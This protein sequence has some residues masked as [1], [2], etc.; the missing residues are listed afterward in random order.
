MCDVNHSSTFAFPFQSCFKVLG[1]QHHSAKWANF[2]G[3]DR[4]APV[5][6]IATFGIFPFAD[7]IKVEAIRDHFAV[8]LP[9]SAWGGAGFLD[10]E[11]MN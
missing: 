10:A 7:D 8:L 3:I 5:K 6:A 2:S 11:I 1:S 4:M 9:A